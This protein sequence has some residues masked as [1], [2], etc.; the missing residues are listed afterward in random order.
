M[1][2]GAATPVVIVLAPTTSPPGPQG[3]QT[4]QEVQ[5]QVQAQVQSQAQAQA[6]A[7]AQQSVGKPKPDAGGRGGLVSSSSDKTEALF[8]RVLTDL[9]GPADGIHNTLVTTKEMVGS[10]REDH[11]EQIMTGL[12]DDLHAESESLS[13]KPAQKVELPTPGKAA[14]PPYSSGTDFGFDQKLRRLAQEKQ[15]RP[16]PMAPGASLPSGSSTAFNTAEPGLPGGSEVPP[17]KA[18][19][20]EGEM[21]KLAKMLR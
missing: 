16:A 6:Q 1:G 11:F 4:A 14:A 5:A 12:A 20:L 3:S 2:S 15:D 21:E 17:A 13:V 8:K 18:A 9:R 19:R 7:Q 10:A